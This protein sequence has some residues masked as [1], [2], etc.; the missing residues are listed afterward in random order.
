MA[1]QDIVKVQEKMDNVVQALDKLLKIPMDTITENPIENAQALVII[2]STLHT[3]LYIYTSING[4]NT[5]RVKKELK[6]CRV[7]FEKVNEF[8]KSKRIDVKAA[9][10]FITHSL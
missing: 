1:E 3:L 10:R 6:R 5:S 7:M 9:K 8:Q 4:S 2:A